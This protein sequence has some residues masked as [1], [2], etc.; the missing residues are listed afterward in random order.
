MLDRQLNNCIYS[1]TLYVQRIIVKL[2]KILREIIRANIDLVSSLS[3]AWN[4]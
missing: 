3:T 2:T 1:L 4:H